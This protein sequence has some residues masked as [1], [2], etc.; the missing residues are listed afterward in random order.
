M[1]ERGP[2]RSPKAAREFADDIWIV[3]FDGSEDVVRQFYAAQLQPGSW[4]ADGLMSECWT[5]PLPGS[6]DDELLC[7]RI[8]E[9]GVYHREAA[10]AAG[11]SILHLECLYL[12]GGL[13]GGGRVSWDGL[14][15]REC[16]PEVP[17]LSIGVPNLLVP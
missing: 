4:R 16:A 10:S 12:G 14:V 9:P 6:P 11:G 15:R 17:L 13:S 1:A 8:D 2:L 5:K 7:V 3:E